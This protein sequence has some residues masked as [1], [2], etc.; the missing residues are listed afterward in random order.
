MVAVFSM[1]LLAVYPTSGFYW[2]VVVAL[3]SLHLPIS[4]REA[5]FIFSVKVQKSSQLKFV[6]PFLQTVLHEIFPN[7]SYLD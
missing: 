5:C 3:G 4:F 2:I 1:M 6:G 7:H